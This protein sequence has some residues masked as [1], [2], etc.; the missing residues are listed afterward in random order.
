MTINLQEIPAA[1]RR[2]PGYRG[3][4]ALLC[5]M[6]ICLNCG[7]E[8]YQVEITTAAESSDYFQML[9][10]VVACGRCGVVGALSPARVYEGRS[11]RGSVYKASEQ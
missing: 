8:D 4:D 10:M 7:A 1:Q 9:E 5:V 6:V 2:W 3:D 11:V